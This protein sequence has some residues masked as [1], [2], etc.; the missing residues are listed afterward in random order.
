MP[1]DPALTINDYITQFYFD[2]GK[3]SAQ[4]P[5]PNVLIWFNHRMHELEEE[6]VTFV[7]NDLYDEW[8]AIDLAVWVNS[9][10]L[11]NGNSQADDTTWIPQLKKLL[12]ISVKYNDLDTK[13]QKCWELSMDNLDQ[14]ISWFETQQPIYT[15]MFRCN[16]K[17]IVIYPTPA[18]NV[19]DGLII[20]YAKSDVNA[21]LTTK[22]DDL[23]FWW[24]Y[25]QT[26]LIGMSVDLAKANSGLESVA[27]KSAIIERERVKRKALANISDRYITATNYSNPDLAY[28]MV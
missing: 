25:I 14:P 7:N 15:P 1:V 18:L 17:N 23:P 21:T 4:I 26:I 5:R 27:Y 12:E 13:Y 19:N 2:N 8:I 22:E 9:Y 20:R 24:Y 16:N 6:I 28:L 10:A 3:A 11:P